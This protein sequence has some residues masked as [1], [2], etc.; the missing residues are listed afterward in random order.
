LFDD[1]PV[2]R[3]HGDC[4]FGNILSGQQGFVLVDF[5]D[6][7]RGPCVQDLWLVIA[8]RSTDDVVH[9]EALLEGYEQMRAFDRRTLRL[10]EPLRALRIVHFAAWI[11]R[12]WEDEAFKRSF[13]FFG[14]ERYWREQ[15]DTLTEQLE[16]IS[17][18]C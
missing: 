4:H 6:M 2:Q 14:T 8:G 11:A 15:I 10:I 9:R 7:L 16:I 1:V 3:I 12:R 5:D 18:G 17:E 13:P